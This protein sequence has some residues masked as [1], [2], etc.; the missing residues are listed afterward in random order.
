MDFLKTVTGKVIAGFVTLAVIAGGISWWQMNPDTRHMLVAG[1]GKIIGWLLLVLLVPWA[2]FFVIGRVAKMESNLAGAVLVAA[3]TLVETGIL[4][5][6]FNWNIPGTT[7]WTF[8]VVGALFAG[9]YNLFT[10]D[11]IAEKVS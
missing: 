11:W 4:A 5:W 6:L 3:Y 8:L 9:A 7:A 2:S 10:C 1:T